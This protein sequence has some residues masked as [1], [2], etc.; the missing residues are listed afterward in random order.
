[1]NHAIK[2]PKD[3]FFRNFSLSKKSLRD[4]F[5]IWPTHFEELKMLKMTDFSHFC[6]FNLIRG[7]PF[8]PSHS[9]AT[10]SIQRKV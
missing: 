5:A 1:M 7:G 8:A 9:P 6:G 3:T 10:L 4:F 2:I